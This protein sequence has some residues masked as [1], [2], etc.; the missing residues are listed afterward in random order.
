ME[1]VYRAM[2]WFAGL[3]FVVGL[4]KAIL[5]WTLVINSLSQDVVI[6]PLD[7]L[8]GVFLTFLSAGRV[9]ELF[10]VSNLF[11][12]GVTVMAVIVAWADRRWGW[13]IALIV[14]TILTLLWPVG[15]QSLVG[16]MM[17]TTPPPYSPTMTLLAQGGS[18]SLFAVPLIPLV[19]AFIL[20]LTGRRDASALGAQ[21]HRHSTG[22]GHV[23]AQLAISALQRAP[24]T[25][26]AERSRWSEKE[27]AVERLYRA[28][29]WTSGVAM[30][31][32]VA[33][34]I[35]FSAQEIGYYAQTPAYLWL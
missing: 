2:M 6:S 12:S 10:S 29:A 33:Y 16:S 30:V 3:A 17:P 14:V 27:A 32:G 24:I 23:R 31:F 22:V 15:V 5:F 20:A 13:L 8:V 26:A 25:N 19:M 34:A 1:K 7:G 9:D 35:M 18:D 28:L 21:R 11:I 4:V